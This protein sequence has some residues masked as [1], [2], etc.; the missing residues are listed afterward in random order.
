MEVFCSPG[1]S[2]STE[3]FPQKNCIFVKDVSVTQW[4]PFLLK[5]SSWFFLS[6]SLFPRAFIRSRIDGKA[7]KAFKGRWEGAQRV[8]WRAGCLLLGTRGSWSS[9]RSRHCERETRAFPSFDL[10][11]STC[12]SLCSFSC[13]SQAEEESSR[14]WRVLRC[15]QHSPAFLSSLFPPPSPSSFLSSLFLSFPLLS[16][17]PLF[18][19]GFNQMLVADASLSFRICKSHS[20]LEEIRGNSSRSESFVLRQVKCVKQVRKFG[21]TPVVGCGRAHLSCN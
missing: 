19:S 20:S 2:L 21:L 9:E 18:L 6:F 17:L 16:S 12:W 4:A 13:L 8:S 5:R 15:P 7:F 1:W 14:R 3:E 11:H 10:V